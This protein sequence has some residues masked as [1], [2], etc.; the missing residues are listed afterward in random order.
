MADEDGSENG[1]SPV[2]RWAATALWSWVAFAVLAG[3]AFVASGTMPDAWPSTHLDGVLSVL[4][5]GFGTSVQQGRPAFVV[6]LTRVGPTVVLLL[7]VAVLAALLHSGLSRLSARSVTGHVAA[8][9]L[10]YLGAFPGAAWLVGLVWL[11]QTTPLPVGGFSS[12]AAGPASY[13]PAAVALAV[14]LAAGFGRATLREADRN[15]LVVDGW[16]FVSWLLGSVV[17]AEAVVGISGLGTLT[18]RGGVNDDFPLL[19]AG[20]AMLVLLSLFASVGRELAWT[21]GAGRLAPVE[22]ESESEGAQADGSGAG[23]DPRAVLR[24][25]ARESWRVRVGA[26]SLCV[27]L[28]VA[29]LAA[30]LLSPSA[31]ARGLTRSV[32]LVLASVVPSALLA[33]LVATV[34]GLGFGLVATSDEGGRTAVLACTFAANVP[35]LSWYYLTAIATGADVPLPSGALPAVLGASVAPLVAI[36]AASSLVGADVRSLSLPQVFPAVGTAAVAAGVVAL[37]VAQA[38]GLVGIVPSSGAWAAIAGETL[39]ELTFRFAL[40]AGLPAVSL[41]LVG[42]GLREYA[43]SSPSRSQSPSRPQWVSGSE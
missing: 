35:L 14:P 34:L 38:N 17:V 8:T 1:W 10:A 21:N 7:E 27:L 13:W 4:T 41:F 2:R 32:P 23:R 36:T 11:G 22:P 29:V 18:L 24:D 3:L 37:V 43:R 31:A 15:A 25:L 26:A 9:G 30:V 6:A 12:S 33:W 19:L 20:T 40:G 28:V 42:D 39:G 16:L 5:F